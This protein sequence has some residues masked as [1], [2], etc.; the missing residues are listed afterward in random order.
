MAKESVKLTVFTPGGE[1]VFNKEDP[2]E[3]TFDG[4]KDDGT[5][6][7]DGLYLWLMD[8]DAGRYMQGGM[9]LFGFK[10]GQIHTT[11][12]EGHSHTMTMPDSADLIRCHA[13]RDLINESREAVSGQQETA[14]SFPADKL[15][16]S[17]NIIYLE[18]KGKLGISRLKRT[19]R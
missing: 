7:D 9:F 11:I 10:D 5:F 16:A 12:F 3:V 4:K 2:D 1:I 8:V 19:K 14:E 18:P 13:N 17:N 15:T 6:I